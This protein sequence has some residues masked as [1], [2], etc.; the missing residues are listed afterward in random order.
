[1]KELEVAQVEQIQKDQ[2]VEKVS[3]TSSDITQKAVSEIGSGNHIS[4]NELQRRNRQDQKPG[5]M[6]N[7]C[8]FIGSIFSCFQTNS[9]D[10]QDYRARGSTKGKNRE[11]NIEIGVQIDLE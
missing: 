5:I 9:D 11:P 2:P 4:V 7:I 1:M 10:G 6:S 3:E 8:R